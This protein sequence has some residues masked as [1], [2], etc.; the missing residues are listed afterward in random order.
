MSSFVL[1]V[2]V[3]C[4]AGALGTLLLLLIVYNIPDGD[5]FQSRLPASWKTV[6]VI[7]A[8]VMASGVALMFLHLRRVAFATSIFLL[9]VL[10][11]AHARGLV[12]SWMALAIAALAPRTSPPSSNMTR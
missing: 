11:A 1:G 7:F 5:S 8:L 6:G 12:I 3:G 9:L 2:I 4:F 10:L